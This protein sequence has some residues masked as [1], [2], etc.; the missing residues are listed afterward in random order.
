MRVESGIATQANP[1][2]VL[3]AKAPGSGPIQFKQV[4]PQEPSVI[5]GITGFD[6]GGKP[7]GSWTKIA[8]SAENITREGFT[9]VIK[10]SEAYNEVTVF[11]IAHD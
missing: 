10:C 1:E 5:V 4:F 2:V 11:W 7:G 9:L 8:A 3:G 6:V